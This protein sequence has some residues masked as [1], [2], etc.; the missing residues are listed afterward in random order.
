M[1]NQ[2]INQ[3]QKVHQS[4]GADTAQAQSNVQPQAHH[5]PGRLGGRERHQLRAV[6]DAEIGEVAVGKS[7]PGD[8]Q[9]VHRIPKQHRQVCSRLRIAQHHQRNQAEP[10]KTQNER[11]RTLRWCGQLKQTVRPP[12][13]HIADAHDQEAGE[14]KKELVGEQRAV[15][16]VGGVDGRGDGRVDGHCHEKSEHQRDAGFPRATQDEFR[17]EGFI[18]RRS[19]GGGGTFG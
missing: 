2:P 5:R 15:R 13:T 12:A 9:H 8:K 6:H 16:G 4:K 19:S 3:S 11:E 7:Q 10:E 17:G 18:H 14:R 1:S